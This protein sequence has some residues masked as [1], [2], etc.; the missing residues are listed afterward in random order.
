MFAWSVSTLPAQNVAASTK[1]NPNICFII[2]PII[3]AQ[4]GHL[5][6]IISEA[7]CWK[8]VLAPLSKIW[9]LI[10]LSV[11]L[12]PYFTF[13]RQLLCHGN[14]FWQI[15]FRI[16]SNKS[17][18][19]CKDNT[20]NAVNWCF[21][22]SLTTQG[23]ITNYRPFARKIFILLISITSSSTRNIWSPILKECQR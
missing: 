14:H 21:S 4:A 17:T 16:S 18:F 3:H 1:P 20:T 9:A 10:A 23:L 5:L 8:P 2:R 15:F 7:K 22:I 6:S 13:R 11:P 19:S 12:S